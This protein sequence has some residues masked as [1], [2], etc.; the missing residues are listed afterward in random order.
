MPRAFEALSGLDFS[1]LFVE[2]LRGSGEAGAELLGEQGDAELF[3]HPA[4]VGELGVGE[5]ALAVFG[6]ALLPG[7]PALGDGVVGLAIF[8]E[9]AGGEFLKAEGDGF[10]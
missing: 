4:V 9:A 10:Q 3:E 1:P 7:L 2:A 5:A 8:G 6:G